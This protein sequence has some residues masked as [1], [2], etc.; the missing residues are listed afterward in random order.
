M[1]L[2][3]ITGATSHLIKDASGQRKFVCPVIN[4][5]GKKFKSSASRMS[6]VEL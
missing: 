1:K 6:T 2:T 3:V 5:N 4:A